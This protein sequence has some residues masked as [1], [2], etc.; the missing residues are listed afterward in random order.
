MYILAASASTSR[1]VT[2]IV[3]MAVFFGIMIAI[4]IV[5]RKRATNVSGFVL[6]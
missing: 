3:M 5:C 6:G 1:I 4:G 2:N